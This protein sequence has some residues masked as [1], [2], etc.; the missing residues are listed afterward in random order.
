MLK[1]LRGGASAETVSEPDVVLAP[2]GPEVPEVPSEHA[3]LLQRWISLAGMQQR[4]I[5]ALVSEIASTSTFVETEAEALSGRFQR[6]ASS[7][8]QQTARVQSMIAL[9]NGIEVEGEQVSIESIAV[10]L[11]GTLTDVVTKILMLS[12]DS[13][14]MVYAL[15][16]LNANVVQVD[17]CMVQLN[18][19]NKT[20]NMLALNA[21]IEA[22]RAGAAGMAF[23]VVAG[24][25]QELS[26]STESLS[27]EMQVEIK[28]VTQGIADGQTTLKRVA[29]VDMSENILA[30]ERLEL[31]L[32]ALVNRGDNLS[33][34]VADASRE[35]A[36]ISS[37]V[38]GMVTGIQFQDRTRQRLEHVIDT[39]HVIGQA[40][41]DI[42]G[43]TKA[44]VPEL[45]S[46]AAADVE[47]VKSLLDKFT[48]SELRAR[49]V[50]Q[51]LDGQQP[52]ETS[53]EAAAV[54]GPSE[55]GSIE[56]F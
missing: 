40:L 44:V 49:F 35:A 12:K 11:E 5:E 47:W 21:R 32:S 14:A 45:S 43:R 46:D 29:T 41:E 6:L 48:L 55:N 26:K 22:E 1:L 18:R 25:V 53:S 50:A 52:G 54:D 56:L 19:I 7:A 4:V 2:K 38:D 10:L 34:I 23:R 30:K 36:Q 31:L 15:D 13:M 9:A 33:A 42:R 27:R 37:D 16:G 39:L 28:S 17:K 20:T 3:E 51:L 24:E 8:E